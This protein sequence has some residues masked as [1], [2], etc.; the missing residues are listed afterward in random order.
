MANMIFNVL[1]VCVSLTQVNL[2]AQKQCRQFA[3]SSQNRRKVSSLLYQHMLY[4]LYFLS[5]LCNRLV[6]IPDHGFLLQ[7]PDFFYKYRAWSHRLNFG[8]NRI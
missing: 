2:V 5:T 7:M 8:C 4:V 6:M 3:D 1:Y